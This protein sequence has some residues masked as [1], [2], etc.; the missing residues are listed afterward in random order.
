LSKLRDAF[1]ARVQTLKLGR[2]LIAF[3]FRDHQPTRSV[4]QLSVLASDLKRR[5]GINFPKYAQLLS[6]VAERD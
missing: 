6:Q 4:A 5:F 3:A 1:D 2:N